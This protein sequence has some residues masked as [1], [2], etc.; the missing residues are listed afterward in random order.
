MAK[1]NK[2]YDFNGYKKDALTKPRDIAWDNWAKF[3]KVGDKAQGFI[4]D[5]FY[6]KAEGLYK[7]QRGITLEQ[8]DGVLI[9]VG[10]KRLPFVLAGT[11]NL[12]IGDPLTV[13][14]VELKASSTK[15]FNPT[16]IFGFFGAN[17]PENASG[18][19]VAEL[20]REDALAGGTSEAE[21]EAQKAFD[22]VNENNPGDVPFDG[23]QD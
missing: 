13:E 20:D 8:P 22:E 2:G 15:G 6:R 3:E 17:L 19:T 18:K 9:N 14:L 23:P 5:V 10:I 7:E 4:R 11:D 1:E 21:L 12:R 16:K